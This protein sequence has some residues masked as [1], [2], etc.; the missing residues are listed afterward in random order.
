MNGVKI[1][2]P[3]A[4]MS[5]EDL[6]YVER[7]TGISLDEDKPLSDIKKQRARAAEGTTPSGGAGVTIEHKPPPGSDY[8][9]FHFPLVRSRC[10]AL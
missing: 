10:W 6:E 9:W 7:T 8:D 3:V 2:V 5:I 4:K 1:A